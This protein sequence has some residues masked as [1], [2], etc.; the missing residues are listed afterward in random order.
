VSLPIL[1]LDTTTF[2][3]YVELLT[4]DAPI[5]DRPSLLPLFWQPDYN[6]G[7][8]Q[9]WPQVSCDAWTSGNGGHYCNQQ[10][11][12]LLKTARDAIGPSTGTAAAMAAGPILK[13]PADSISSSMGGYHQVLM[14]VV[15]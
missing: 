3:E 4:G 12:D 11:E 13:N 14:R 8:S 1:K 7:W 2:A 9:L 5:E 6:D 10:V 15:A